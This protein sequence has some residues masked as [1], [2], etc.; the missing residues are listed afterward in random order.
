M[1]FRPDAG[2]LLTIKRTRTLGNF[3][4]VFPNFASAQLASSEQVFELSKPVKEAH[5][6]LNCYSSSQI[7]HGSGSRY[8]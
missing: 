7:N 5:W 8:W 1:I 2:G 3:R 6:R 4:L